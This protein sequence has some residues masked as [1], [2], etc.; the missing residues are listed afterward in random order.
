MRFK[1]V[2][3]TCA[4]AFLALIALVFYSCYG[5]IAGTTALVLA[6]AAVLGITVYTFGPVREWEE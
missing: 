2:F 5:A 6:L 1:L 3:S 4:L